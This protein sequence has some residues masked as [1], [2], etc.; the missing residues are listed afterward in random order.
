MKKIDSEEKKV[1]I[2][3]P[4]SAIE[5]TCKPQ[6]KPM[7]KIDDK[8]MTDEQ[9]LSEEGIELSYNQVFVRKSDLSVQFD[10]EEVKIKVRFL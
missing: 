4:E 10:G 1:K 5:M 7:I 2:I 6:Q 3:T 9:E 8:V